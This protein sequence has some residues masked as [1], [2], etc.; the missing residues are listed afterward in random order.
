MK[1]KSDIVKAIEESTDR[2][3]YPDDCYNSGVIY[4]RFRKNH[5]AYEFEPIK[6]SIC[7]G[8]PKMFVLWKNGKVFKEITIS[9]LQGDIKDVVFEN[10]YFVL[11]FNSNKNYLE[12]KSTIA[13]DLY[14]EG[15]ITR[16]ECFR[17]EVDLA[18]GEDSGAI[19]FN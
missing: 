12:A 8:K 11:D 15:K 13:T 10:K 9:T 1:N 18:V 16:P 14:K 6:I 4:G 19:L 3:Q 2:V 7:Y 5:P 17:H